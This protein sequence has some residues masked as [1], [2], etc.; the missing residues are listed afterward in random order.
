VVEL[1]VLAMSRRGGTRRRLYRGFVANTK[2]ACNAP[3]F[4]VK[5]R[6]RQDEVRVPVPRCRTCRARGRASVITVF[7]ATALGAAVMPAMWSHFGPR[8]GPPLWLFGEA[9]GHVMVGVGL[10]V[11]FVVGLLGV[12]VRRRLLGL[13]TLNTYP[14]IVAL[15]GRGWQWL[16]D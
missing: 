15:R 11:G 7:L 6:G 12:A 14:P 2:R 9:S 8:G 13:R 10:I 5:T 3:G 1:R 4:P 16:R